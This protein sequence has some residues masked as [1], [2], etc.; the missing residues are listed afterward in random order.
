MAKSKGET[1]KLQDGM[2]RAFKVGDDDMHSLHVA[3]RK[4]LSGK[5]LPASTFH[6]KLQPL[7]GFL[8]PTVS[9]SFS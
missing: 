6:A 1:H 7:T 4:T 8:S 9:L 5:K 3:L 2:K